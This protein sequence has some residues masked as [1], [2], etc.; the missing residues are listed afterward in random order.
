MV[1]RSRFVRRMKEQARRGS[2]CLGG[3]FL[4][5]TFTAHAGDVPRPA[6][7]AFVRVNQVGYATADSAKRAYLMASGAETG[8]TFAVT[9]MTP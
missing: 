9:E 1:R 2:L 5:A 8:A 4:A 3:M 7:Q 6:A